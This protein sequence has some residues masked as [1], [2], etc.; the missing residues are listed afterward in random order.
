MASSASGQTNFDGDFRLIQPWLPTIRKT[1]TVGTREKDISLNGHRHK[2]FPGHPVILGYVL[3]LG[4]EERHTHFWVTGDINNEYKVTLTIQNKER[5]GSPL[6]IDENSLQEAMRKAQGMTHKDILT[7]LHV[8]DYSW[9]KAN[10]MKKSDLTR[11][12]EQIQR[13]NEWAQ[14]NP[15]RVHNISSDT[16]LTVPIGDHVVR[17]ISTARFKERERFHWAALFSIPGRLAEV[18]NDCGWPDL[19]E[20]KGLVELHP[21]YQAIKYEETLP[22]EAF[23]VPFYSGP[24]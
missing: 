2:S 19:A 6:P 23:E 4:G 9:P 16:D 24:E 3:L 5:D 11:L 1:L 22:M 10:E 20:R 8:G 12:R 18:Y 15:W 21:S 17:T 7:N 14:L 13:N